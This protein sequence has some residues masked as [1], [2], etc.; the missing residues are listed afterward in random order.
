MNTGSSWSEVRWKDRQPSPSTN[1]SLMNA[2]NRASDRPFAKG[3]EEGLYSWSTGPL[4]NLGRDM[5]TPKAEPSGPSYFSHQTVSDG[6]L[7]GSLD[8]LP[9]D[10][11]GF[12]HSPSASSLFKSEV[13]LADPVPGRGE[14]EPREDGMTSGDVSHSRR[15]STFLPSFAS[16][17]HSTGRERGSTAGVEPNPALEKSSCRGCNDRTS[18]IEDI[19]FAVSGLEEVL[20]KHQLRSFA[21]VSGIM[22]V[23][24]VW[25]LLMCCEE[26]RRPS[27]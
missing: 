3:P 10:T 12:Q 20:Q 27:E 19:A 1:T 23:V 15:Q 9:R 5:P 16:L 4:G 13:R 7:N 8:L 11:H 25:R 6:R 18:A 21:K 14:R 24:N 2:P 22:I 17:Q 26:V